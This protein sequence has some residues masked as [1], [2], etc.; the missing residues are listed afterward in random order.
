MPVLLPDDLNFPLP[1]MH[2]VAQSFPRNA[3][4]DVK[5]AV[6]AQMAKEEILQKITPGARIAVAVGSRG[7]RNLPLIVKTV[8]DCVKEAGGIPFILSAMGSHGSG[9]AEGQREVLAV[10]GITEEAMGVPIVTDVE[11]E[12]LGK[13]PAGIDVFFDKAALEADLIIPINRVK[14]HTDF[15]ADIQSGLCKMLVIGLGNHIGCTA[16]HES[17]FDVFGETLLDA[18]AVIF[19]SRAK[20]GFGIAILENAYDETE[21]IEAIPQEILV[22]R[23]KELVVRAREN[24]PIL[25]IPEIDVLI[26]Q[27][28]GKNISG[29]GFDPNILGRSFILKEFVLPVPKINKMVLLDLSEETHGNGIGMGLFDI[30]TKKVFD[31]LDLEP[32][33]ANAV[34]IKFPED[35]KIPLIAP[36]EEHAVRTGIKVLR[37]ADRDHLKIVKIKNTLELDEIEVSEALLPI[38]AANDRLALL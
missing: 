26:V 2:R 36:S 25:M 9:T 5:A 23:E 13:T 18:V 14:L 8:I 1:K 37:G 16:M 7:I 19:Q 6:E 11:V 10:Y 24:M 30:I 33:Y 27:E 31:Q 28:I 20:V 29:A 34:A 3:L 32:I 35:A 12:H 17:D 15:V 22:A 4:L 38:V 21:H